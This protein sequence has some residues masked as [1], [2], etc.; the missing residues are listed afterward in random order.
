MGK[1]TYAASLALSLVTEMKA[2]TLL[3]DADLETCGDQN[4]LLGI[5]QPKTMDEI[6][7]YNG[8]L[9]KNT[10]PQVVSQHPSGLHYLAAV[11]N[12]TDPFTISEAAFLQKLQALSQTYQFIVADLE[13]AVK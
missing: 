7:R 1:S 11:K 9:N 5:R 3:L 10:L 8:A 4:I 13:F 2:P 6:T 12:L